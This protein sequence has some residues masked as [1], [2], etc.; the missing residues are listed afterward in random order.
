MAPRIKQIQVG[1]VKSEKEVREVIQKIKPIITQAVEEIYQANG[2]EIASD[3][4]AENVIKAITFILEK[5]VEA[6]NT[7]EAQKVLNEVTKETGYSEKQIQS[8][9]GTVQ[10]TLNSLI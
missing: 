7:E 3:S 9:L 8:I 4:V 5:A 1:I 2:S 6:T 10:K